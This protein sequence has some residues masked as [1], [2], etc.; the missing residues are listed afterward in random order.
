M[1]KS[2][3]RVK[4]TKPGAFFVALTIMLGVAAVNTG[5][6]LIY[7][8]AALM[9]SLMA[10]SGLS[11][12]LNLVG[13]DFKIEV[14]EETYASRRTL[15][16]IWIKNRKPYLPSFL[17]GIN[18][19][20]GTTWLPYLPPKKTMPMHL[21]VSFPKRGWQKLPEMMVFSYF[22]L[23]F[24]SRGFKYFKEQAFVVYPK[25]LSC[26]LPP[27]IFHQGQ[28]EQGRQKGRE[29]F[30]NLREWV[31]GDDLRYVHWL[32]TA[33][34][35]KF[36]IKEYEGGGTKN[37]ILSIPSGT[38]DIELHLSRLTYLANTLFKAGYAVGLKTNSL[39]LPPK[40]GLQ[41]RKNILKTLA[42]YEG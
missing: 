28:R 24:F 42:L 32:A 31:S 15:L 27:A 5:N 1:R 21:W 38:K 7:L 22:P 4:I 20:L 19:P 18:T 14:P 39:Y 23:Y 40:R 3:F 30:R 10:L 8:I 12:F 2:R 26:P 35:N 17:L 11:S 25:P 6:N 16:T 9:L 13:L 34:L 37:I 29:E 41:Q 33:R 36:V